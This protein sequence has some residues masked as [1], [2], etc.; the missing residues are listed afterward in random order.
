MNCQRVM[1]RGFSC[2]ASRISRIWQC[3]D[4]VNEIS[5]QERGMEFNDCVAFSSEDQVN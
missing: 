1:F 4:L 3:A 5:F 2:I